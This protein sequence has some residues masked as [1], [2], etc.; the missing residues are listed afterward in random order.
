MGADS[1][2]M[3]ELT[4]EPVHERLYFSKSRFSAQSPANQHTTYEKPCLIS[5]LSAK[6]G[7]TNPI[8]KM[9][10]Q[11]EQKQSEQR[12]NEEKRKEAV[13]F[14][15]RIKKDKEK[16]LVAKHKLIRLKERKHL[17]DIKSLLKDKEHR[18]EEAQKE[19]ERKREQIQGIVVKCVICFN[20]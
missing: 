17:K 11:R 3:L 18:D 7:G 13:M 1:S 16:Q 14:L 12:L 15:N 19:V 5:I 20:I 8:L 4:N 2:K 10:N 9:R 6:M